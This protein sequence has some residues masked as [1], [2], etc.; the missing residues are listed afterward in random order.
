MCPVIPQE[1]I[2]EWVVPTYGLNN[3]RAVQGRRVRLSTET[4]IITGEGKG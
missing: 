3:I 2:L 4:E 1:A